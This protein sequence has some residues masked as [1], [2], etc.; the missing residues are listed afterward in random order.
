MVRGG[1]R[2]DWAFRVLSD[3]AAFREFAAALTEEEKEFWAAGGPGEDTAR[4]V[5]N[6]C[7][8]QRQQTVGRKAQVLR[9]TRLR[10][11]GGLRAGDL[12]RNKG[13]VVSKKASA[14]AS[15]KYRGSA[16]ER[17]QK[18]TTATYYIIN[19]KK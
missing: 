19:Q 6:K 1:F 14:A 18:A 13:K 4:R 15:K 9:G 2:A 17:W 5:E 16:V 8:R 10:T 7:Y 3:C 11:G 12:M